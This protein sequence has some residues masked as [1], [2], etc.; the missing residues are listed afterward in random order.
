MNTNPQP[1]EEEAGGGGLATGGGTQQ[2]R[3]V[4]IFLGSREIKI[5]TRLDRGGARLPGDE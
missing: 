2:R 1:S 5:M 4:V 3:R